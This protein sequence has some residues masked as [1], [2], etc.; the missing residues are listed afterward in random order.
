MDLRILVSGIIGAATITWA[1]VLWIAGETMGWSLLKPFSIVISVV[2]IL[3][4]LFETLLWRMPIIRSRISKRP[5]I[6]GTWRVTLES[7]FK[8][9]S[10]KP[11]VKTT[12]LVISQ[13][14]STLSVR[15]FT[16]R[17]HSYSLTERIRSAPSDDLFELAIVYQNIP[18]IDQ[19]PPGGSGGGIHF[20]SL[21]I[22]NV[23]YSPKILKGHY[24]TDRRTEGK[25]TL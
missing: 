17:A 19:R 20:G 5:P 4:I 7:N 25:L 12:Y 21:L 9:E 6:S 1:G 2:T 11:I 13:T 24:W 22:P 14:L 18:D 3:A 23:P 10:G 15:M 16:D 8:D